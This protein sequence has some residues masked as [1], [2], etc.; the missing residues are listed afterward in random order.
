M[1]LAQWQLVLRRSAPPQKGIKSRHRAHR[2]YKCAHT[3]L[4]VSMAA[5][6]R[7]GQ[8]VHAKCIAHAPPHNTKHDLQPKVEYD[9]VLNTQK[10][11]NNVNK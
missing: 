10:I 3:C 6:V 1:T 2:T 7:V 4:G 11:K 8:H 5:C 9:V